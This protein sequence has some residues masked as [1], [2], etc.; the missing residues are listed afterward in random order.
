MFDSLLWTEP[1]QLDAAGKK[2]KKLLKKSKKMLNK[3]KDVK[4][5][6]S[7][8]L[9]DETVLERMNMID[10]NNEVPNAK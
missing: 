5:S 10:D 2:I 3:T 9:T 6:L 8:L 4:S 1:T 7:L